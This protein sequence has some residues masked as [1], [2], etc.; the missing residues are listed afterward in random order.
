M[1]GLRRCLALGVSV[2]GSLWLLL[3]GVM[4]ANSAQVTV[5]VAANFAET[6]D[7][8]QPEFEKASGHTLR[9]AVGST[10]KLYAQIINGAPFDVFLSADQERPKLLV[11]TGLAAPS[12]R[13]TY[14]TGRLV[15]WSADETRDLKDG[16]KA[17]AREDFRK[18]AVPNP[19]LAPY[20]A[21]AQQVLQKLGLW[22]GLQG[23][24]VM[25]ENVGQTYALV[26]SG[27]AEIGFVSLSSYLSASN[28]KKGVFWAPSANDH[29]PI[30]QDAVVLKR[31]ANN[32]AAAAFVTFLKG[33]AAQELLKRFGYDQEDR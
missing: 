12:S 33:E 23:R 19:Q 32:P 30:H 8:L 25:G 28:N 26:A 15:L 10:G 11:D 7:H 17:L 16:A 24:M 6:L 27:N 5:A 21:A 22:R 1:F 14:A 9:A 3:A 4:A 20:G 29:A 13:F 31:A 2:L 18:I